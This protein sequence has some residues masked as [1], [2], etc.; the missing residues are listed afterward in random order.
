MITKIWKPNGTSRR[1]GAAS[2]AFRLLI[3]LIVFGLIAE[4]AVLH[5]QSRRRRQDEGETQKK[6]PKRPRSYIDAFSLPESESDGQRRPSAQIETDVVRIGK[7]AYDAVIRSGRYIVGPGDTFVVIVDRGE[8]PEMAEVA[9]GAEGKLGIPYIG[10]VM[11]AGLSLSD[12]NTAIESAI[13]ERF[14][15]LSIDVTLSRLRTF[16]VNILGEV[17]WPGAYMATGVEQASELIMRAGGL[18]RP[19]EGQ[20]SL[21]NIQIQ[22]LSETGRPESMGRKVDLALW[23]LAGG[24]G[25]NPFLLDG[26]QILVPVRGD[27]IGISGMVRNPGNYEFVPGDRIANL[28]QLGGGLSGEVGSAKA[29]LLRLH[30]G[31][32]PG[33]RRQIDLAKAMAGDQT[34]NIPLQEGDKCYV[35]GED[36]R[37][38]LEGEVR[39]P[40]AYP[41]GK[42]LSLKTLIERAGGFTSLASL[43]Q[44]SVIRKLP[45]EEKAQGEEDVELERFLSL[46]Q[47]ELTAAER[48]LF[49]M[50]TRQI[51]GRLPVDFVA[52]FQKGQKKYDVAL[53]G[54]DIVRVPRLIPIVSVMGAVVT[55]GAIPYDSAHTVRDYVEQAGGFGARAQKGDIMVIKSNTGNQV[56]ASKV[57]RIDPG[58]TILVP[59]KIPGEGWRIFRE[60]LVVVT[61]MVTLIYLISQT[62]K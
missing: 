17:R 60:A 6:Q 37:V 19:P 34:A 35:E 3:S 9:V 46:S 23:R 7:A 49:A 15:H 51:Q 42:G 5:A 10:A 40:G 2:L 20:S 47:Q 27:S 18:L 29:E 48:A 58:D 8:G 62:G 13:Q 33:E 24:T 44:A 50:K 26:D 54:G 21:R 38:T 25:H 4:P 30:R 45:E 52:L 57:K 28:V 59:N 56:K 11:V 1:R 22:R 31:G 39:F 16:P 41:I 43:A 36:E 14:Q 55:P 53:E 32:K 12:T 61:Q